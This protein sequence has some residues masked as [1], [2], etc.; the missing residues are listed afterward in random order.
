MTSIL[1]HAHC[2]VFFLFLRPRSGGLTLSPWPCTSMQT[3]ELNGAVSC[4]TRNRNVRA[5]TLLFRRSAVVTPDSFGT[6]FCPSKEPPAAWV[7]GAFG[8]E[9]LSTS[10]HRANLAC[11]RPG[12]RD[13]TFLCARAC[14][15]FSAANAGAPV[16]ARPT[17]ILVPGGA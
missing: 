7:S 15:P 8:I 6:W 1:A 4:G 13:T 14:R 3:K 16:S 5:L 11:R 2:C 9:V 17:G 10:F 12:E